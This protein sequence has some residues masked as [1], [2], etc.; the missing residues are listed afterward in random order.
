MPKPRSTYFEK[1]EMAVRMELDHGTQHIIDV[2]PDLRFPLQYMLY[3]VIEQF[4]D[5]T[6]KSHPFVSKF[7]LVAYQQMLF[8]AY[9]L[10][11]DLHSR[12][13]VSFHAAK[14][15]SDPTKMDFLTKL[16]DCYVPADLEPILNALAPTFDPQRRLQL[17]V[18]TFAG[19]D[20]SLDFGRRVPQSMFMLAHHILASVRTNSDPETILRTFYATPILTTNSVNFTPANFLGAYFD[21]NQR[22]THHANWI[23]S[24]FETVFN[25]VIGRA[26]LQRPTLAKIRLTPYDVDNIETLDTYEFL[27]CYSDDNVEKILEVLTDVSSFLNTEA[28]ASK[29][30]GQILANSGG[31]SIMYHSL[32]SATLPTCHVLP[33]PT[34]TSPQE[35]D[36]LTDA[37]FARLVKFLV[38]GPSFKSKLTPPPADIDTNFYLISKDPYNP[39]LPP[40]AIKFL[41]DHVILPLMFDGFNRILRTLEHLIMPSPSVS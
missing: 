24:R 28:S 3:N 2:Q 40:A 30:L 10:I 20:F 4:P 34:V 15:K 18:P 33:P 16:L 38:P 35:T 1:L 32:W 13:L 27:L 9:L 36:E 6:V 39:D 19:F 23:N 31:I 29:K 17:Y 21:R 26:L 14:F 25:P 37:Q 8:N 11:C 5:L 41:I 22:P 12:E 7:T